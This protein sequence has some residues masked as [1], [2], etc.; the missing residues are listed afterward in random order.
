MWMQKFV[1]YS[2]SNPSVGWIDLQDPIKYLYPEMA[3]HVDPYSG[4]ENTQGS[5][6]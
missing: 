5:A 6:A 1:G 2:I 3:A 4:A